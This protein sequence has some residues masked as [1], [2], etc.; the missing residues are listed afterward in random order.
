MHY[1]VVS[2]NI[3]PRD[4][5]STSQITY[6]TFDTKSPLTIGSNIIVRLCCSNISEKMRVRVNVVPDVHVACV[7]FILL[8]C[9]DCQG[10]LKHLN[11]IT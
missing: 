11:N 2:S 4:D 6:K 3:A 8:R 7:M 9:L 1:S 10:S 5:S